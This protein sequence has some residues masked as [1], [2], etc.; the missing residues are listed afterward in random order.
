MDIHNYK[1]QLER[2]IELVQLD[3]RI[4]RGNKK[5]A[6]EFKDYL[7]S[8]GIGVAK[9]GRYLLDVRKFAI[10]LQKPFD[11][12]TEQDIRKVIATI[13][14]GNL[15]PESKKCFKIML[16]KLYRFIRRI[17]EKGKYPPEVSWISIAISQ[18]H[19]KLPEELLTEEEIKRIIHHCA[20]LRDKALVATLATTGAR[21]S[22]AATMQIKHVLFE[23][24]GARLNLTG[25]TGTRKILVISSAP[26]LQQWINEH[27][28]NSNPDAYLWYN[29]RGECLAYTRISA[30]LKQAAKNAK[31]KKR[32]HLHLLR[33]SCAT[34]MA[35]IM[36]EACM[37]Q[38]FGWQQ[39]SRMCGIYIHMSGKSTDEAVL[40]ANG[41]DIKKEQIVS[42]LKPLVCERCKTKNEVTN[43]CCKHCG[44]ILDEEFAKDVM[45]KDGER[46][47]ADEIMDNLVKDPEILSLIKKKLSV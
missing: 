1:R 2:Q 10:M 30:I 14:Q 16:R 28:H 36:S 33:H 38:Y 42:K 37:K 32:V 4:S 7:L 47:M 31:I 25:K 20:C 41:I 44:L 29:P 18:N 35:S 3:G 26:Y 21:V 11:T 9:I 19:N 46:A 27:P 8:E 6:L 43:Q 17:N 40:R 22:E 12:A 24:H 15:A 23:E 5:F 39:S 34:R 45:K 13:E